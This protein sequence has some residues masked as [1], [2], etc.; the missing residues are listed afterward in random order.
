M[1]AS[2]PLPL[3]RRARMRQ[4]REDLMADWANILFITWDRAL[5]GALDDY[6]ER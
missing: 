6:L 4:V 5:R 2:L 1:L 3:S